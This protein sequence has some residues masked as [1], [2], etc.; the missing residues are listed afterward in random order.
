MELKEHFK[1][2][3]NEIISKKFR[4]FPTSSIQWDVKKGTE[5]GDNY[6]GVIMCIHLSCN[7]VIG[8]KQDLYFVIKIAPESEKFRQMFPVNEAFQ[9][10]HYIYREVLPAFQKFQEDHAIKQPFTSYAQYYGSSIEVGKE[11][12]LMKD[13]K[14][15]NYFMC[16]RKEV[17]DFEHSL[18][19][20]QELGRLH[21][22]SFA[23]KDK[24]PYLFRAL[25]KNCKDIFFNNCNLEQ[26]SE[27]FEGNRQFV[28]EAF[29]TVKDG[30]VIEKV[31][32]FF[33]DG[34]KRT[35][36][37]ISPEA[38]GDYAV[39]GHGDTWINNLLFSYQVFY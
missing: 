7:S 8:A 32:K 38:A 28:L 9:R 16:N 13:L 20:F 34:F 15:F 23:M 3:I 33:E 29:D 35:L 10:E 14:H 30:D 37:W 11:F 6:F 18:L 25:S 26:M 17:M 2:T 36:Q 1:N 24:N 27:S 5:K 4:S 21:S 31:N 12:I 39:I 22:L 19:V